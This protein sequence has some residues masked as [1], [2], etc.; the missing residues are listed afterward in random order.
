MVFNKIQ[1]IISEQLSLSED[2]IQLDTKLKED[3]GMDSI[4]AVNLAIQLE[5]IFNIKISDEQLQQFKSVK[6]I[7]VYIESHDSGNTE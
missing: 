4:D 7:V 5:K 1:K 2:L 6:D 3:L